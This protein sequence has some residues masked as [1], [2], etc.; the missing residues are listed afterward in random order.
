[1]VN[2]LDA[3][4]LLKTKLYSDIFE[5]NE[6]T[7][8]KQFRDLAKL[9]HPDM[10]K[11]DI[12]AENVF[13]H[14][15][16]L[17]DDACEAL[18]SNSWK[19]GHSITFSAADGKAKRVN[20]LISEAFECGTV[21]IANSVV[22]YVFSAERKAVYD[23]TIKNIK[24]LRYA[25]KQMEDSFKEMLPSIVDNFAATSGEYVLV[26]RKDAS[27]IRLIDILTYCNNSKSGDG[28]GIPHKQAAWI[29]S[30]LCNIAC[31]LDFYK[32]VH[33]GITLNN[34]FIS[35]ETHSLKLLG[36]WGCAIASGEKMKFTTKEV[37]SV[38]PI[39]VRTS[40]LS[41]MQTDLECIKQIGRQITLGQNLEYPFKQWITR[42][43]L[44]SAQQEFKD[45]DIQLTASYGKRQFTKWE[46]DTTQIYK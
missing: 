24:N 26:L 22:V 3:D 9:W 46:I 11:G 4:E 13:R 10:R 44:T 12:Q 21:Y 16:E 45:W 17:Y 20:F 34:C 18:K 35:P 25:D 15:H 31:Y 27:S 32:L 37:L 38:M 1:M 39:T 33:N 42:G 29:M 7:A 40:K 5:Q 19:D 28:T 36:G 23:D 6:D 30:R 8:K 43:A 2:I 14:I 41:N